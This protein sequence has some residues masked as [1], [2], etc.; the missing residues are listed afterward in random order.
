MEW[1]THSC[2]GPGSRG[3]KTAGDR[4]PARRAGFSLVETLVA[5]SLLGVALLLT[6][7]LIY[8]EPRAL[9][10]LAAHEQ[11]LGALEGTLEAVRA[12]LRVPAGRESVD[13]AALYRPEEA[14]AEDLVVWSEREPASAGGLYRLTLT[15]RYRVGGQRFQRTVETLVWAP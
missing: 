3:A 2:T 11:A 13:L 6:L 9:R 8:Q 7:S 10:R 14:I 15:A 4:R 1:V 12:G 5:L